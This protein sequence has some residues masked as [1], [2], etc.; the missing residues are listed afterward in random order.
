M[1]IPT[2]SCS[3]SALRASAHIPNGVRLDMIFLGCSDLQAS[4]ANCI[5][6]LSK[7]GRKIKVSGTHDL[8]VSETMAANAQRKEGSGKITSKIKKKI[9]T[10]NHL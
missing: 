8:L 9:G 5:K 10:C 2:F 3:R 4:K 6:Q 7:Q 1:G